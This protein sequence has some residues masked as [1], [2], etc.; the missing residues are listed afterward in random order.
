MTRKEFLRL[1]A[2]LGVGA[3]VLSQMLTGCA[4]R[5]EI[6]NP[7]FQTNFS[8]KV[9]IVGAGAAGLTAGYILNRY[10]VP[11]EIIEAAP[12]YGG[13]IKEIRDFADFP[14]DLGAEWIHTHPSIL[15]E[16]INDETVN[17]EVDIINY[18]PDTI[19][20]WKN[21]ELKKRNFASNFYGEHKFKNSGWF[22]F[23]EQHI[24]PSVRSNIRLNSPVNEIDYS[25]D[26]VMLKTSQG[27]SFEADK[28]ILTVPLKILQNEFISFSP[29]IPA[30]QKQLI[31]EV[32]M[33]DGIKIFVEFSE[34]FYPGIVGFDSVFELLAGEKL[35]YDA[36]FRKDANRHVL[37][38]FTVGEPSTEYTQFD[39]EEELMTYYMAQLD[40]IFDGKPSQ[41]YLNHAVQNWS[42]EPYIQGSYSFHENNNDAQNMRKPI[43]NKL[44]F[45]GEAYS[46]LSTATVHGA[47]QSAY[48]AVEEALQS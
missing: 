44:F 23:F 11:F 28:V 27:D 6:I 35:L 26:K 29:A 25:A 12:V 10:N 36:A 41:T 22:D 48:E 32:E 38:L 42:K 20:I 37:G 13:R 7:S 19:H 8:G 4:S 18:S 1:S 5:D 14:I 9:I 15:A 33:P 16:I 34:K 3:P 21:G 31:D 2:L 46:S 43:A 30:D 45:A 39:S 17:A 47:A 24:V 40:E